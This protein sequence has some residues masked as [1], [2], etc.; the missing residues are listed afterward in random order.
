MRRYTLSAM[1]IASA[2]AWAAFTRAI[3]SSNVRVTGVAFVS[4]LTAMMPARETEETVG[5]ATTDR[6]ACTTCCRSAPR[7]RSAPVT[8]S[9]AAPWN[10][11]K[12][13]NRI[14]R[15]YL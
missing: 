14:I 4:T 9:P 5:S 8:M 3:T 11:S 15:Q 6:I 2:G 13:R 10:G 7:S 1:A 12:T